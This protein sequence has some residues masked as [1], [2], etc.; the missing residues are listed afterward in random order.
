[1]NTWRAHMLTGIEKM[2]RVELFNMI[3]EILNGSL[4][5]SMDKY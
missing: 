2:K 4:K 1:M 3:N 5:I